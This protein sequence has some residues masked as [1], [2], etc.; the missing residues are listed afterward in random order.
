MCNA[1]PISLT[2]QSREKRQVP[3]DAVAP[4][5]SIEISARLVFTLLSCMV[6]VL[7]FRIQELSAAANEVSV[8]NG[9]YRVKCTCFLCDTMLIVPV[10]FPMLHRY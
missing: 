3:K 10:N 1:T 9:V 4:P 6:V 5:S 8:L 7:K 2:K